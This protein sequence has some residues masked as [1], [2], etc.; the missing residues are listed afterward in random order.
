MEELNKNY[1]FFGEGSGANWESELLKELE[2]REHSTPW[3]PIC[4]LIGDM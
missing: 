3:E 2:H 4:E 1:N